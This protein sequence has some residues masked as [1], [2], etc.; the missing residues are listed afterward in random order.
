MSPRFPGLSIQRILSAFVVFAIAASFFAGA[1]VAPRPEP[2]AIATDFPVH[3]AFRPNDP[4]YVDQWGLR[5]IDAPLAWDVTLGSRTVIVAVVDTGVVW[6]HS[7][8]SANMWDNPI[9]G[10]HG[11]DFLDRDTNPTET[12]PS[13]VYHGTG[14]AGVIAALIDN[15]QW[16][17]G[18]AQVSVMALRALGS[19]GQGSSFNTSQAIRWAADHGA[20]VINLS[21]GTNETF[22]GP[23]D[24]QLAV[25]Y[26]WSRGALIV[27][28]AGN[29]GSD[30]VGD[31][32]LDYPA[33]LANVVS[34]AAIDERG[35]RA[36]F[37]NYGTGLDLSAPG[38]R[39]LTLDG[40][41][42]VDYRRGTSFSAPFV[43]AAAAMLWSL[44]SSLTNVEV[45]N[46]LNSSAVPPSGGYGTD[47]GWGVLNLWNG[48]N[49]LSQPFISVNAYPASVSRSS[50]FDVTWSILGP[51]GL[52]VSDTHVVWGTRSGRL[53]NATSSLNGQ[54]K[55]DYTTTGL[56]MPSGADAMFFKV[57][58]TVNGTPYESREYTVTASNL[59][60]FLFVLYQILASNVLY[61]ALFIIA[62]AAI[63]AFIPQRRA[64]RARRALYRPR[65]MYPPSYYVQEVQ[66][67]SPPAPPPS[68]GPSAEPIQPRAA[69]PPPPPVEFVRRSPPV[70]PGPA[71]P[72]PATGGKKRCPSCGTLVNA[73]NMFCF[74]CGNPFR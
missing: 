4:F 61:L 38:D 52:P 53:G 11:Y 17:A 14:V 5:Q 74:F 65:T 37:S 57:V 2:F 15:G 32:M 48:I 3:A 50:S 42:D 58:A 35:L 36:T 73:D 41:N 18:T 55:Q 71:P 64:A 69:A 67:Q 30:G 19:S 16:I 24:I 60:D 68:P 39:I 66:R 43:S 26:A 8:I 47:Y 10:S 72:P 9:D 46:I 13:G 40:N 21:L 49:A 44:D 63:V 34:V 56:S 29:G 27:A 12:D 62:L 7:D 70:A 51:A 45:W 59:P 54:T 25:D 23:T 22:A 31:P 28:A 1:A 33:R 20:K 6:T